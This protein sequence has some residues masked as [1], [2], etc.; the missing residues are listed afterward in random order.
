MSN[1]S[2]SS[3]TEAGFLLKSSST[4]RRVGSESAL[5]TS[6]IDS[7]AVAM[8]RILGGRRYLGQY[9]SSVG[10]EIG[11]CTLDVPS[12]E[13][14]PHESTAAH[15]TWDGRQSNHGEPLP[16]GDYSVIGGLDPGVARS[17]SAPVAIRILAP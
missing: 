15:F 6:S 2:A 12:L 10:H 9:L 16:P 14:G 17:P 5:N 11:L 4:R 1:G 7:C 13:L 8:A 3:L